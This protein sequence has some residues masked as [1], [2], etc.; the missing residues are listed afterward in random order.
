MCLSKTCTSI[1]D[2]LYT[3]PIVVAY[4]MGARKDAPTPL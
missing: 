2:T 3:I 1:N 4:F